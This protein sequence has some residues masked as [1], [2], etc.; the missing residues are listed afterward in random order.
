MIREDE[1]L[2]AF[3]EIAKTKLISYEYK[4]KK[5]KSGRP[6]SV[7]IDEHL[8]ACFLCSQERF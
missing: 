8:G 4:L 3:I 6:F 2:K 5:L 7:T 1:I